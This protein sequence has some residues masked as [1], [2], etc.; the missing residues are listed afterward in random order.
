MAVGDLV[1]RAEQ[2]VRACESGQQADEKALVRMYPKT[3]I[4]GPLGLSITDALPDPLHDPD[5][6]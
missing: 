2:V 1:K 6:D 5:V 3:L 4:A